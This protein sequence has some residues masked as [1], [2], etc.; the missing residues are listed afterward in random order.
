M[1]DMTPEERRKRA[2]EIAQELNNDRLL[3][4]DLKFALRQTVVLELASEAG[5]SPAD[6]TRHR[7]QFDNG[8]SHRSW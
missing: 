3:C 6:H 5:L 4:A 1:P 2:M 7:Y 8:L